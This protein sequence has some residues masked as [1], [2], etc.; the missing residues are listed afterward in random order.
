[1]Q[2]PAEAASGGGIEAGTE[3]SPPGEAVGQERIPG[4]AEIGADKAIPAR[5]APAAESAESPEE[6]PLAE[7]VATQYGGVFYLLNLAQALGLYGDF[8]TPAS[9]GIALSPWDFLALVG[10][11]I[12]GPEL[13]ADPLWELLRRLA[14]RRADQPPGWDFEPPDGASLATWL[15]QTILQVRASL[16]PALG[17]EDPAE[18]GILLCAHPARILR[19]PARLDI[20]FSLAEHPLAIRRSGLDRDPGWI[21]AAGHYVVY[22]Y[23]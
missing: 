11:A 12:I 14:G 7:T 16:L 3:P 23:D 22:H 2:A 18:L 17:L 20:N 5:P 13:E 1:L 9:P 15:Q 10:R 6:K 4:A 19:S 8:T 21:P